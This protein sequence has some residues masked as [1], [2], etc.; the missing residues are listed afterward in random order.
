V[1]YDAVRILLTAQLKAVAGLPTLQGENTRITPISGQPWCRISLLPAE[2][3]PLSIG[4]SGMNE[5]RG[6]AQVDLF[7]AQDVGTVAP[8]AMAALVMAAFP[9]G[10]NAL[11]GA[12]NVQVSGSH[13]LTAYQV[14]SWYVVPV[15]VR[16]SSYRSSQ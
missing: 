16:W 15:V 8:N 11:S 5:H 12:D 1:N 14:E 9:R 13:Q 6:I 2:P 7:Y 3:I 4:P 10:F